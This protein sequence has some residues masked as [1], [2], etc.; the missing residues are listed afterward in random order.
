MSLELAIKYAKENPIRPRGRTSISRFGV[1]LT[2]GYTVYRGRNSY[3]TCPFQSRFSARTGC[4]EKIF[5]HA[6]IEAIKKGI[7]DRGWNLGGFTMYVARLLADGTPACSYPCAGCLSAILE[8]NIK[9]I[10]Y[11]DLC[12]RPCI[13][14]VL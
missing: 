9:Q 2:D 5:R 10:H 14:K 13:R 11:F 3:K 7:K 8:F 12:G 6:E 1:I 4:P